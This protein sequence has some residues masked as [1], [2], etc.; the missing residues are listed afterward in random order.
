MLFRFITITAVSVAYLSVQAANSSETK[1]QRLSQISAINL[2]HIGDLP[3]L[4]EIALF[5]KRA[6]SQTAM[7]PLPLSYKTTKIK[8]KRLAI[9][10]AKNKKS[11]NYKA[12]KQLALKKKSIKK[13]KKFVHLAYMPPSHKPAV[14]EIFNDNITVASI[15]TSIGYKTV[16]AANTSFQKPAA[17]KQAKSNLKSNPFGFSLFKPQN[18]HKKVQYSLGAFKAPKYKKLK[19]AKYI[20]KKHRVSKKYAASKSKKR[21]YRKVRY[22]PTN[23]MA[24]FNGAGF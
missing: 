24:A 14:H 10:R 7:P 11:K 21:K 19:K 18:T 17:L 4:Q 16:I 9:L 3:S 5:S 6:A 12:L 13:H 23:Y 22:K 8:L 1:G 2:N 20:K 15:N